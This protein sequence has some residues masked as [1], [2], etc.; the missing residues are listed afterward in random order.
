MPDGVA[1][2][3]QLA[4]PI[5]DLVGLE[6]PSGEELEWPLH[7][8]LA[9]GTRFA[10]KRAP[11]SGPRSCFTRLNNCQNLA[12]R[13]LG[14]TLLLKPSPEPLFALPFASFV[15]KLAV[16]GEMLVPAGDVGQCGREV[17]EVVA[18]LP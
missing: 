13:L 2:L 5:A 6:L 17:A 7:L 10:K 11:C 8:G 14:P 3:A 18:P 12:G 15:P 1:Q 16:D 4:E 9:I